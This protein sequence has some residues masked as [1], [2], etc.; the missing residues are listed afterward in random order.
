M[1]TT[2]AA[3]GGPAAATDYLVDT[4]GFLSHVVADIA[5]GSV[6]SHYTRAGNQLASFWR[7]L[8]ATTRYYHGDGLGSA[9]LLSDEQ[10]AVTDSYQYTAFG[11]IL[12][13]TGSDEHPY[14][15]AG[16]AYES[17]IGFY[18]N[19]AR[20][21]D[22]ANGQFVSVDPVHGSLLEPVTLHRYLYA[23]ASPQLFVDPT[24]REFTA[25]GLQIS[26]SARA[27]VTSVVASYAIGK[28]FSAAYYQLADHNLSRFRWIE[29]WDLAAFIPGAFL[30]RIVK[31]PVSLV[32]RV[33]GKIKGKYFVSGGVEV[34]A[35][36]FS[37][38]FSSSGGKLVLRSANGAAIELE[39]GNVKKGFKHILRRHLTG[40]WDG[41]K[42]KV[43]SFFPSNTS[44]G[45]MLYLLREAASK[46][47]VGAGPAQ[48]IVLSNGLAVKLVVY[49][50]KIITFFPEFGPG[51]VLARALVKAVP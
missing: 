26:L 49:H 44:P 3:P 4:T 7:P 11:E 39:K 5:D 40:F 35:T 13:H 34:L 14:R 46:Y 27:Y 47:V 51:V 38:M 33:G 45:D 17:D 32:T 37:R 36:Q 2:V 25:M 21:M 16:E 31:L 20:W 8:D 24:G 23:A 30:T 9:R 6:Q 1:R 15:F 50:G 43:T 48:S 28:L 29:W 42:E 10:G 41:S 12:L 19:R 22:P 18:Y